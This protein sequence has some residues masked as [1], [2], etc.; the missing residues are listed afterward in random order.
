MVALSLLS[1]SLIFL[2]GSLAS[3]FWWASLA[4]FCYG[5]RWPLLLPHMGQCSINDDHHTYNSKLRAMMTLYG[6][7]SVVYRDN[8]MATQ[9]LV[10]GI[11]I[12]GNIMLAILRSC[13]GN[14]DV[15]AHVMVVV[16][17]QYISE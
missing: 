2:V 15:V 9:N 17:W 8:D 10:H 11:D 14:V 12:N 7:P 1:F 13:N 16:S 6:M 3:F 4:S 5:L